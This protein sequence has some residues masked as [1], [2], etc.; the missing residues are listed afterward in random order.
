M[1]VA[2]SEMDCPC[3][4]LNN[5]DGRWLELVN[6]AQQVTNEQIGYYV[7]F[8]VN[9]GCRCPQHNEDVGGSATSPHLDGM[10]IDLSV[11][12]SRERMI[13]MRAF[14]ALGVTRIGIGGTYLHFDNHPDK[15]QDV[16]WV[17]S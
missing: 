17:Y 12:S 7:P 16:M 10:A 5:V 9:S 4:G 1:A 2:H 11:N 14:S 13:M 8:K 15:A 6:E 3:C